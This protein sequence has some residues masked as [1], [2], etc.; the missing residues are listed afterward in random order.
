M[1]WR[2]TSLYWSNILLWKGKLSRDCLWSPMFPMNKGFD[3]KMDI[4]IIEKWK[5]VGRQTSYLCYISKLNSELSALKLHTSV[6]WFTT[7]FLLYT[8]VII[9]QMGRKDRK[10]N[11][12][13]IIYNSLRP[14]TNIYKGS[15]G[16]E[17]GAAFNNSK[18][19][20]KQDLIWETK[21]LFWV[22]WH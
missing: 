19:W 4:W 8:S 22:F 15:R 21:N 13:E 7:F 18:Q 3:W 2:N 10:L 12:V 5:T 6:I 17:P 11:K 14:T 20:S 16:V 9:S 1:A